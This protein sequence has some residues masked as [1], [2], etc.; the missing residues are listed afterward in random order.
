MKYVVGFIFD[1]KKENVLLMQ[2]CK[3]EWQKGLYNGIGGKMEPG[4]RPLKAMARECLEETDLYI[5]DWE[6][7]CTLRFGVPEIGQLHCFTAIADISKAKQ[8]EEEPISIFPV[9]DLPITIPNLRWLIPLALDKDKVFVEAR[10]YGR[11]RFQKA[12]LE[13]WALTSTLSNP[14]QAPETA[15]PR[16]FGE[17]YGHPVLTDGDQIRTSRVKAFDGKRARTHNTIYEL[18][19]P[20]KHFEDYMKKNGYTILQYIEKF[21]EPIDV[22]G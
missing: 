14:Y 21:K 1:E 22:D 7:F 9:N 18:G 11:S 4:E 2:K 15:C 3:P 16:L 13:N 8:M 10:E 19:K 20:C 17:V 5:N 12:K 6:Q